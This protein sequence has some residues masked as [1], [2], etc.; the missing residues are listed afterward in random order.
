[1]SPEVTGLW[2][3]TRLNLDDQFRLE[4][5]SSRAQCASRALLRKQEKKKN[6][7]TNFPYHA[8]KTVA[9]ILSWCQSILFDA[10][11]YR[12]WGRGGSQSVQDVRNG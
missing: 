9:R 10:L 8:V 5:P 2:T 12:Q 11:F 3:G 6:P 7:N 1:M 4:K